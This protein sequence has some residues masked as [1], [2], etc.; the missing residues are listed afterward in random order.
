M[1]SGLLSSMRDKVKLRQA[2]QAII[3]PTYDNDRYR[4]EREEVAQL[5]FEQDE[6]CALQFVS[7]SC[8]SIFSNGQTKG[9]VADFQSN[10]VQLSAV[11]DGYVLRK[12]KKYV[13]F[14]GESITDKLL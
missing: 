10:T 6:C 3:F 9:I 13:T 11:Y 12:N 14:G 5:L 7:Q 4:E 1:F 2:D 8:C